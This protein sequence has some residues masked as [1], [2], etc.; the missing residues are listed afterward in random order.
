MSLLYDSC[1]SA[2]VS[3]F[4][5][6]AKNAAV[7][8]IFHS[9]PPPLNLA[10]LDLTLG[11]GLLEGFRHVKFV[12]GWFV[13]LLAHVVLAVD[14]FHRIKIFFI[15]RLLLIGALLANGFKVAVLQLG[16][17]SS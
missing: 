5:L 7:T 9:Q 13:L 8:H 1:Y 14:D 4:H 10:F 2:E 15:R 16:Q 17:P 3:S 12:K 11:D 6:T